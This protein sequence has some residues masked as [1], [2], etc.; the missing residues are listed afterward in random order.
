MKTAQDVIK[1]LKLDPLPFEG[2]FYSENH[3]SSMRVQTQFGEMSAIT[4]IYYLV[5][6]ESFSALHLV[7]M[8][9]VF[10]FYMGS[11]VEM[12]Q[13]DEKG[14]GHTI[15]MGSDIFA[16][17]VPQLTVPR[18]VWQGTKLFNPKPNDWALLG[19]DVAPGYEQERFHIK[20]S[21]EL[22]KMFP[23]HAQMIKNYTHE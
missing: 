7:D 15:R 1:A 3:R 12:F 10:H 5:T 6:S 20:S 8:D 19:C 2:G 23:A 9:E 22:T 16:G 21:A 17:E 14:Q 13:I 11:P 18:G 4:S